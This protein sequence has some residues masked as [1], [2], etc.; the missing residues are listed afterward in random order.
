MP[1]NFAG[2]LSSCRW[3]RAVDQ[4]I[5]VMDHAR[6]PGRISMALM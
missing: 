4:Q 3:S 5:R 1:E 6:L 2:R